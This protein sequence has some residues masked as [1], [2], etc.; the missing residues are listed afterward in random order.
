M[1]S[2]PRA[3]WLVVNGGVVSVGMESWNGT[4]GL[5]VGGRQLSHQCNPIVTLAEA[6]SKIF[7]YFFF[8]F[9]GLLR[10]S[11]VFFSNFVVV[12]CMEE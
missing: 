7:L 5:S 4:R 1:Y 6:S 12:L 9:G 10:T 2:S 11:G 3:C 8:L